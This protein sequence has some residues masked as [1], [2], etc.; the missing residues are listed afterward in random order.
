MNEVNQSGGSG[1]Q[2]ECQLSDADKT[3]I[4][5]FFEGTEADSDRVA[6]VSDLLSLL[7]TPIGGGDEK[8]AR[9]DVTSL[10]AS[11][12]RDR[13]QLT[14]ASA[15]SVDDW[16]DGQDP[17]TQRDETHT[18]I[19]GLVTSGSAYTDAERASLVD[20]TLGMIQDEI[21]RSEKRYI[22]DLPITPGGR[23]RLADLVSIAATLL[24]VASVAIPVMSGMRSRSMQAICNNN[25]ATAGTAFG[26]YA[27][28]NRDLL[29]MATAGFGTG[30]NSTWMDVG[31]TPERSNSSNLYVLVRTNHT[32][33]VDLACPTNPDAL[34]ESSGVEQDW[35]SIDEVSYS[36]RIMPPGGMKAYDADHP[37]RVVLLSD[38][39]PVTRRIVAGQSVIPEENTPNHD[40][41]GQ[42]VLGLDGSSVWHTDPVLDQGDNLW[43][44]R[45]IEQVIFQA[46]DRLGIIK[47]NELPDGP[48][49]AFV[50]P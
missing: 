23:F 24:L 47:G 44:P 35:R 1:S 37:V 15:S 19:A 34:L 7:N 10:L 32:T 25:M 5:A 27:G 48:T 49:D 30:S 13:Q 6:R 17:L 9:I 14:T 11:A 31:S 8:Q 50:G 4:D 2:D 16:M 38:R 40:H 28:S 26:A 12:D 21:N 43:F 33:L 3:A 41:Q 46:R 18:K 22:L 29:P 42:H 36:Y 20:R 39:S 45:Q